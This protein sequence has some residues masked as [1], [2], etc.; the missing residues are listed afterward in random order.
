MAGILY[1]FFIWSV[2][3]FATFL[4]NKNQAARWP[5]AAFALILLIVNH[6][7]IPLPL[8]SI[9]M[10]GP[11]AFLLIVG[12]FMMSKLPLKRKLYLV[13]SIF[14]LMIGYA[15]IQL[16]FMYDPIWVL[17]NQQVMVCICLFALAYFIY[18]SSLLSRVNFLVLGTLQGEIIFSVILSRWTMPYFIGSREYLDVLAM[19]V[20]ALIAGHLFF[21][22]SGYLKANNRKKLPRTNQIPR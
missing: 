4:M 14:A 3:I 18:P 9:S 17:I 21:T 15:G 6:M 1:L 20:M 2:W 5:I 13:T 11:A 16:W 7:K 19:S 22:L 12:Y 10:S 8:F